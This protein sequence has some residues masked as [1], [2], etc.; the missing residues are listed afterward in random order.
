MVFWPAALRVTRLDVVTTH[1][2]PPGL[3]INRIG[4]HTIRP[5]VRSSKAVRFL[6]TRRNTQL[7]VRVSDGGAALH[8]K[9]QCTEWPIGGRNREIGVSKSTY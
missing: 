3:I 6:S 8:M 5:F 4:A 9:D 2:G 7:G 1:V